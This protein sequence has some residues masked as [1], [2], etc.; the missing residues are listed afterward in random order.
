MY[1]VNFLSVIIG[2][3]HFCGLQGPIYLK[4]INCTSSEQVGDLYG[5][6]SVKKCIFHDFSMKKNH[7]FLENNIGES[8]FALT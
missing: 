8:N 3:N 6:L 4:K 7:S 2:T 5:G 1:L